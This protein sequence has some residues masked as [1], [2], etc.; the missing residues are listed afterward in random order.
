MSKLNQAQ[1]QKIVEE[2]RSGRELVNT[3]IRA[4]GDRDDYNAVYKIL[5][6]Y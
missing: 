4:K 2:V 5:R 6:G 3:V 1:I